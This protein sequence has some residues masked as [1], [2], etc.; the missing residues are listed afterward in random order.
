MAWKYGGSLEKL[1]CELRWEMVSLS[2]DCRNLYWTASNGAI[3]YNPLK[4][5]K[6]SVLMD[7]G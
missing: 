5:I 7:L 4:Y 6:N 1:L 2:L 3:K